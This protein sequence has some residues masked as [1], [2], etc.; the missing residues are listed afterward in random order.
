MADKPQEKPTTTNQ[1][2][3]KPKP[4]NPKDTA[5][6]RKMRTTDLTPKPKT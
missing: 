6:P 2:D 4:V 5:E 1:K 3:E